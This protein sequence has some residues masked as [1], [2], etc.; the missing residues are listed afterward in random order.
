MHGRY[1]YSSYVHWVVEHC[2]TLEIILIVNFVRGRIL[3]HLHV[4]VE[5]ARKCAR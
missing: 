1:D 2:I 3:M 4:S 5:K